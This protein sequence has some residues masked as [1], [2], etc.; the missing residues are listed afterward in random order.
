MSLT[1][2]QVNKVIADR[3]RQRD[4]NHWVKKTTVDDTQVMIHRCET[5]SIK[6]YALQK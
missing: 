1:Y 4:T 6:Q 5:T 2:T 3:Q